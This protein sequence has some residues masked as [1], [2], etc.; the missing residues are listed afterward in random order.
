LDLLLQV[1]E[2][3]K[4]RAG[5]V[6]QD[7]DDLLQ[8]W[9]LKS[10]SEDN[11]IGC[12]LV[13]VG[14]LIQWALD[15]VIGWRVLVR[16]KLLN[17]TSPVDNGG[18]KSLKEVFVFSSSLNV[19]EVLIWDVE[20][21]L[22]SGKVCGLIQERHEPVKVCNELFLDTIWPFVLLEELLGVLGIHLLQE[23]LEWI[24]TD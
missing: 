9:L 14:D 3:W 23:V 21:G 15:L 24:H 1:D 22:T 20:E 13:P 12:S 4:V 10:L 16:D 8:L 5:G 6:L 7:L 11:E 19:S 17:L 18:L 2:A